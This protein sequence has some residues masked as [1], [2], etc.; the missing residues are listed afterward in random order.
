MQDA[1]S[2]SGNTASASS[3][4]CPYSYGGGVYVADGGTFTMQGGASVSGNT[5]SASSDSGPY[6]YGG[7][8][9]VAQY[10]T[11]TMQDDASVSG[12][13]ASDSGPYSYGGGVYAAGGGTLAKTGG[14]IYGSDADG[15]LK[16]TAGTNGHAVYI[17][18]YGS[19]AKVRDSTAGT[20]VA[21]DSAVDGA[22]G[23]WE[24]PPIGGITYSSVSGG[25]W[26]LQNDGRRKSP[27]IGGNSVTKARVSF[28]GNRDNVSITIQLDVS[29]ESGYDF[30]FISTLDNAD[31]AYNSGYYEGSQIS[32]EQSVTVTIPVPAAGGHFVDIGYRKDSGVNGGSDCAWFRVIE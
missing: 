3:D 26:T 18:A 2:V 10:G 7:G 6:S 8:V 14:V 22:A 13:T 27:A 16:N 15:D 19:P 1:A 17:E 21:L 4:S 23:G 24:T 28:T 30:A 25:G 29:S 20:E 31:A 9:Y 32:G 12:N 5:A 11:F